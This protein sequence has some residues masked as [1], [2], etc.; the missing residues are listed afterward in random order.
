[1]PGDH[2][3]GEGI[4]KGAPRKSRCRGGRSFVYT[5]MR[6]IRRKLQKRKKLIEKK[7]LAK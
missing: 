3:R 7:T 2:H 1:L 4:A 6:K 5:F